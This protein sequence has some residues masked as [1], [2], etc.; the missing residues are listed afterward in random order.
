MEFPIGRKSTKK[1]RILFV[2]TRKQEKLRPT[3]AEMAILEALWR[4]GPS[5]VREL[6]NEL[7]Q[8]KPWGYTTVLKLLQIML[9]KGLVNRQESS[10]A[11]IYEAVNK[12]SLLDDMVERVFEGSIRQL[13][14]HAISSKK[15]TPEE[16]AEIR[17]M[18]EEAGS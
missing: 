15:A 11:H 10:R 6:Q 14:L 1:V 13:M 4:K 12:G 2:V 7:S 3:E 17:K 5:T 8:S 16:L 18:L 9:E